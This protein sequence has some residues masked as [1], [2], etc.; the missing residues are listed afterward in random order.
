MPMASCRV[1]I[2]RSP[3]PVEMIAIGAQELPMELAPPRMFGCT[4]CQTQ[5]FICSDCDRGQIYCGTACSRTARAQHHR[6]A[7]RRYQQSRKGRFTHA[8]RARRYR[9]RQ[10][11][12]HNVTDQGSP[13]VGPDGSLPAGPAVLPEQ[14][15][16]TPPPATT[17]ACFRCSFCGAPTSDGVRRGFLRRRPVS[18]THHRQLPPYDD[19]RRY[20]RPG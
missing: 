5:V 4:R 3:D 19:P 1:T 16:R 9:R 7:D 14:R 8:A 11:A 20:R 17:A 2:P 12:A 15:P 6:E 18:L 10:K 13:G